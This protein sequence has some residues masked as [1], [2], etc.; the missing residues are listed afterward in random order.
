M[1]KTLKLTIVAVAACFCTQL[2]AADATK[3]MRGADVAQHTVRG[4]YRAGVSEGRSVP[5][6]AEEL[7][8]TKVI[9]VSPCAASGVAI[10]KGVKA[11]ALVIKVV[12]ARLV[13]IVYPPRLV[14]LLHKARRLLAV[15]VA[16]FVS[17][18]AHGVVQRSDPFDVA[19]HL[20]AML[21]EMRRLHRI[22]DPRRRSRG[23]DIA[24]VQRKPF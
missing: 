15:D 24:R 12:K 3:S 10:A 6:Y 21:E 2:F 20:I 4:Q 7:G 17:D 14:R 11:R 18:V 13:S 8:D 19:H 1:N 9:F 16:P 23:Q 22:A 5:G